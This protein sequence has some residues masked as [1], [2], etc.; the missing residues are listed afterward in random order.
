MMNEI[1]GVVLLNGNLGN[2]MHVKKRSRNAKQK[3]TE[4]GVWHQ[5]K[6]AEVY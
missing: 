2:V 3:L 1:V 4:F 5:S 6:K